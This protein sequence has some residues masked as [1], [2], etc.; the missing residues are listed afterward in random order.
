MKTKTSKTTRARVAQMLA[1][2]MTVR[3]VASALG[4]STQAV[5]KHKDRID[6]ERKAS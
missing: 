2:G 5:Y 1:A 6:A 3:E 4:L